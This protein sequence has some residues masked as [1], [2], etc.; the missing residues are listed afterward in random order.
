MT[1]SLVRAL[2]NASGDGKVRKEK[3]N[4]GQQQCQI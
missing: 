2:G 3:Y 4:R 1:G